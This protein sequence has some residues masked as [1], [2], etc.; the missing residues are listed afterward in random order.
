[1]PSTPRTER[2]SPHRDLKPGNILV[3]RQG[4]KLLDFGLAK[5]GAGSGIGL[6]E[7]ADMLTRTLTSQGQILG[8]LQ[9][10]SPEQLQCKEVDSRSDLFSFGCVLYELLT[11]KRAFE[12][13]SSASVIAAILEREPAPLIA[14]PP[15]DRVVRR[16]LAKDPDQRFQTARDLKYNLSLAMESLAPAPAAGRPALRWPALPWILA[17]VLGVLA[18]LALWSPWRAAPPAGQPLVRV[19]VDLGADISLATVGPAAVLSPDGERIVFVAD[20]PDG[21]RRL[22]TRRL[23][24]P[25]A[26]ALAKTEAA[27]NPFFSPDGQW[28]G[29]F[30]EGKLKKTRLDG[31]EPVVL[32]DAPSGRGA[33]WSEDNTI[34]AALDTRAGLTQISAVGGTKTVLT[35]VERGEFSHRWPQALPG[36]KAVVFIANSVPGNHE[37]A[38]IA[39]VSLAD[40]RRK[41]LVN[42]RGMF[43]RYLASGHLV[44][45]AK[46][47]LFAVPFDLNSLETHGSS[48]AVLEDLSYDRSYGFAQ[49][50]FARNGTM[51]YRAGRSVGLRTVQ[52]LDAAGKTEPMLAEPALYA[53]PRWSPD[54][55]RLA[56]TVAEG[57]NSDLWLYDP[58]RGSRTPLTSGGRNSYPVWSSDGRYLGFESSQG[59]SWVQADGANKPQLLINSTSLQM[60]SSFVGGG[61]RLLV[62]EVKP[63]GGSAIHTVSV[64]DGSGQP[65]AGDSVPVLQGI[66]SNNPSPAVSANGRWLAYGDTDSGTYEVYVR[67]FPD[68]GTKWRISN[69]G[70]TMPVWSRNGRE[71][72][73]RDEDRRIMVV[74]YTE[75]GESF[76]ADNPRVWSERQL[77]D[78]GALA[79]F[80]LAPDGKRFAVV[81]RAEDPDARENRSHVLVATGFFDEIRRRIAAQGK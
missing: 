18:A 77:A 41:N 48:F 75:R 79:T 61:A 16:A 6:N 62:A 59:V 64:T 49:L 71:L 39:V 32:C 7:S 57:A 10:M 69:H 1:M 25:K 44:Y 5:Q 73:Y 8:T 55:S 50:D 31:G 15:L 51:L 43:P 3:T 30:A 37:E 74:N 56:F 9:Y 76:V 72:F 38:V 78:T 53:F 65:R 20:G 17:A 66:Q 21:T 40:H 42:L 24:Q 80:D 26:T 52:W 14:A 11:G 23:D 63:G 27:F 58:R 33:S 81:M 19:D 2:G 45:V 22:F 12:G 13:E 28:V 36:G 54:G 47:A 34:I 70:G 68:R 60:P 46:G 4:I 67:A 35:D 29:F